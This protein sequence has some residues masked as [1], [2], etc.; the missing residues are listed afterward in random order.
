[1]VKPAKKKV[2]VL[3]LRLISSPVLF[4]QCYNCTRNVVIVCTDTKMKSNENYG[5][6]KEDLLF[7][8]HKLVQLGP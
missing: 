6:V 2:E 7:L 4:I 8:S 3:V 5:Q 1:M